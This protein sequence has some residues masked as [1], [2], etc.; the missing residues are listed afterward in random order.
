MRLTER[1]DIAV[2]ILIFL[3]LLKGQ[4]VSIDLLSEQYIGHRAQIVAA[5]QQLR[6]AGMIGSTPGR[7]G[8]IWIERDASQISVA[9]IVRMFETDFAMTTC[10]NHNDDCSLIGSCRLP[11][12]LNEALARFFEPLEAATIADLIV[13]NAMQI[14][15][16]RQQGE[17]RLKAFCHG[18]T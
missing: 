12:L 6:K 11:R 9:E 13:P 18:Q 15:A 3:T 14:I 1:T 5:V 8:G 7:N 17:D 2:R 16:E 10:M 4:K